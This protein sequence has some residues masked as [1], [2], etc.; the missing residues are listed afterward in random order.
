MRDA[1]GNG[2]ELLAKQ[3]KHRVILRTL[4]MRAFYRPTTTTTTTAAPAATT[5]PPPSHHGYKCIWIPVTTTNNNMHTTSVLA[6]C[7]SHTFVKSALWVCRTCSTCS[8]PAHFIVLFFM[9]VYRT[10][11][12]QPWERSTTVAT[13]FHQPNKVLDNRWLRL[14]MP[15]EA[16]SY[17]YC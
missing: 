12:S 15:F 14:H 10:G 16:T 9:T 7:S 1:C 13:L 17:Y 3:T 6:L 5:T 11:R 2:A 8:I 4:S